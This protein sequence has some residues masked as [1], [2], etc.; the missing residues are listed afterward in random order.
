MPYA[1]DNNP[2]NFIFGH[3]VDKDGSSRADMMK[4]RDKIR[5]VGKSS[6]SVVNV[7]FE[8]GTILKEKRAFRVEARE[9]ERNILISS[10]WIWQTR[11]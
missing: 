10:L 11:D 3:K 7:A 8:N 4:S 9:R 2:V 1:L 6:E 5:Q